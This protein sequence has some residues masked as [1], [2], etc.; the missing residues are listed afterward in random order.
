MEYKR[1]GNKYVVRLENGEEIVE[2]I[3]NFAI[4]EGITLG[5][6][7]GIGAVNKAKIGLFKLGEKEYYSKEF[8]GD[9]EVVNLTGNISE[10]DG[11]VYIHLHIALCDDSYNMIGGHLNYAYISATGEIIIDAIEGRV[12]RKFNDEIGLNLLDL[13]R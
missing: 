6:V 8:E 9:L 1:F 7:N 2:S 13:N 3:K 12:D 10:M 5:N 11:E 4:K